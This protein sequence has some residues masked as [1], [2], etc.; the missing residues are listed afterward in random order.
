MLAV[1]VAAAAAAAVSEG[2]LGD[3][4][5]WVDLRL[6]VPGDVRFAAASA[7]VTGAVLG[8]AGPGGGRRHL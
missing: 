7:G 4:V 5:G 6:V 3:G 8:A 1:L 2:H